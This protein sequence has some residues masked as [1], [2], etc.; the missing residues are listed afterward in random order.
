[1]EQNL[2]RPLRQSKD[3]IV[4][5]RHPRAR[6]T[7]TGMDGIIL[8]DPWQISAGGFPAGAEAPARLRHLVGWAVLAP[9][10]HNTLVS[11]APLMQGQL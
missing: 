6:S 8:E 3:Q 2:R 4:T 10:L 9:S 1:M 11:T 7:E 5:L